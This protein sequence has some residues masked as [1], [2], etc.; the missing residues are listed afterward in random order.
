MVTDYITFFSPIFAASISHKLKLNLRSEALEGATAMLGV[1]YHDAVT[2]Y[3]LSAI[4]HYPDT[5]TSQLFV[6]LPAAPSGKGFLKLKLE[7]WRNDP[8]KKSQQ[9]VRI[10]SIDLTQ[11]P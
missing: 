2:G 6:D 8:E 3:E 10:K 7:N 1:Y 5:G 4:Q 11:S 9:E